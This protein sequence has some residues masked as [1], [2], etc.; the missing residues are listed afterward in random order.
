M[1]SG[2]QRSS[3]LSR[4]L[5]RVPA[6][7][8]GKNSFAPQFSDVSTQ[9]I[10]PEN[11]PPG[12]LIIKLTAEDRDQGINGIVRYHIVA[13]NQE[14]HFGMDEKTGQI[15][16][17]K[18]LDYDMEHEYNLTIQASDLA[19]QSKQS[20]SVL[21]IILTDVNDNEPFFERTHYD[22]YLK[23]NSA[24][25]SKIITMTAIDLD[26]PAMLPSSTLLRRRA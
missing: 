25:G 4:G 2:W 23:E 19:Y 9:V 3:A 15:S 7:G 21:K 16:I 22:A 8:G 5:R 17:K 14:G 1:R 12:S 26:S 11:E 24:P 20:Q 13:G 18:A 10:I 6:E